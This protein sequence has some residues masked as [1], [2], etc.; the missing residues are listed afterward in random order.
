MFSKSCW[1]V[2]LQQKANSAKM[3]AQNKQLLKEIEILKK[4]L[5]QSQKFKAKL[6]NNKRT[7]PTI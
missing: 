1:Q 7:S 6:P 2:E 3:L 4:E 5:L